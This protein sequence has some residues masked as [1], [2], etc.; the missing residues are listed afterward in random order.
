MSRGGLTNQQGMQ[1][2]SNHRVSLYDS[3]ILPIAQYGTL[4]M[5]GGGSPAN[6]GRKQLSSC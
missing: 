1:T 6:A 4:V 5:T 2:M 3:C